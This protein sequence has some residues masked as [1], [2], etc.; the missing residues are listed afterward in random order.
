M[1]AV[2]SLILRSLRG[3]CIPSSGVRLARLLSDSD[4]ERDLARRAV[5]DLGRG[6]LAVRNLRVD[7]R[8]LLAGARFVCTGG[9]VVNEIG[10]EFERERK[11][12]LRCLA[13]S[14]FWL[15]VTTLPGIAEAASAVRKRTDVSADPEDA[16]LNGEPGN[17]PIAAGRIETV[18]AVLADE[19]GRN[20][21]ALRCSDALWCK[22]RNI[23]RRCWAFWDVANASS[24]A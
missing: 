8:E 11:L 18:R 5:V 13:C 10:M 22:G 14:T 4:L 7:V 15:T 23:C 16:A 2:L 12:L 21:A 1:L 19:G 3:G 24:C 9:G 6:V 17:P 20:E